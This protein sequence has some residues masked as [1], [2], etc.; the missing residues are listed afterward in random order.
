MSPP[1]PAAPEALKR[2]GILKDKGGHHFPVSRSVPTPFPGIG[3]RPIVH[4]VGLGGCGMQALAKRLIAQGWR[5]CGSDTSLDACTFLAQAQMEAATGHRAENVDPTAS[6]L[7][8]STAVDYLNPE[9]KR[10]EQLGIPV[11]S[12][13]EMLG[14]LMIGPHRLAVAGTHGKST[15]TAMAGRILSVGGHDPTV[16][17]GASAIPVDATLPAD[18]CA[19]R[20]RKTGISPVLVEACE[21]Q[22]NFL[23]LRP[24]TAVISNIEPDHFDC[25]PTEAALVDAFAQFVGLLP[26]DGLLIVPAGDLEARRIAVAANCRHETFGLQAE[27]DWRVTEIASYG[28]RYAF[29]I[30]YRGK[31]LGRVP[32]GVV[33]RHNVGN[34]LAA[35]ALATSAGATAEDLVLGLSGF[36]GLQRR[37]QYL[38][39]KQG[40][41]WWDDYA[42]HPTS[43]AATIDTLREI[44]PQVRIAAIFEPHQISRTVALMDDFAVALA[45]VDLVALTDIFRAREASSGGEGVLAELARRIRQCG[46]NVLENPTSSPIPEALLAACPTPDVVVTMGAGQVGKLSRIGSHFHAPRNRF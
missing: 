20:R 8:Y 3:T 11:L 46:G 43:V 38:G 16:I 35:A 41:A 15:I 37:L 23:K 45:K 17:F 5:V 36:A 18:A 34:A 24:N 28:G 44:Y 19:Q 30:L 33:G 21:Y 6:L 42:H 25:F 40:Q 10:A 29:T 27:C 4:M 26:A 1:Y 39:R 22:G 7:I 14:R 32:L 31:R 9:L 12:Y 13:P 2:H